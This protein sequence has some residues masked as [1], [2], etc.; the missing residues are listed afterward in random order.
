MTA[1]DVVRRLAARLGELLT[2]NEL[3]HMQLEHANQRL[4]ML[5][6]LVEELRA[7]LPPEQPEEAGP[8]QA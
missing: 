3:L 2:E 6:Q 5:S 8:A 4:A 7:K 1:N